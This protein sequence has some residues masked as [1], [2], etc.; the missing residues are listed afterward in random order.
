VPW[1]A[2]LAAL[3]VAAYA[4]TPIDLIPDFQYSDTW[5]VCSSC[6]SAACWWSGLCRHES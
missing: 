3:F 5:T 6:R 2:K 4:L 1:Y